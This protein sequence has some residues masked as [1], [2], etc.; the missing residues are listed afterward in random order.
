MEF[1]KQCIICAWREFCKK[2]YYMQEGLFCPDFT[3]DLSLD[4]EKDDDDKR[5]DKGRDKEG[6][7]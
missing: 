7:S 4:K 1:V 2:K 5:K 6:N 3:K